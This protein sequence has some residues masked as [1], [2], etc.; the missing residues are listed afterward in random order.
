MAHTHLRIARRRPRPGWP[1]H[2]EARLL[3]L[4]PRGLDAF[5]VRIMAKAKPTLAGRRVVLTRAE[6]ANDTWRAELEQRGATVLELPLTAI[7]L[8][9]AH[10][11]AGEILESLGTYEW[12][13]FTSAN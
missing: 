2:S 1:C 7:D 3:A 5:F 11:S 10:A 12:I 4:M 9:A 13:V 6:G 8:G